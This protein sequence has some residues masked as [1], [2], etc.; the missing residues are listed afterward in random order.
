M[1]WSR[2]VLH[3][4]AQPAAYPAIGVRAGCHRVAPDPVV[5]RLAIS[6]FA[7]TVVGTGSVFGYAGLATLR[8]ADGSD[9]PH[10]MGET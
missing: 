6:A 5:R 9:S 8:S 10:C 3:Y 7:H 1:E 4:R 2:P